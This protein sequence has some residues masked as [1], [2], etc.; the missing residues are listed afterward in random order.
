MISKPPSKISVKNLRIAIDPG[1]G[2]ASYG[3]VGPT[4]LA[5]KDIN[6]TLALKTADLLRKKGA[7]VF[8]TR[9]G[10][11]DVGLYERM[12]MAE[13]WGAD[14]FISIHNNAIPDGANPNE[15]SGMGIYYYNPSDAI[16][17]RCLQRNLLNKTGQVND[18]LIYGNLAVP[19]TSSMV[20]ILIECAYIINPEEEM[21]LQDV[22]FQKRFAKGVYLGVKDFL[23]SVE[24]DQGRFLDE[25]EKFLFFKVD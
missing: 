24:D 11:Y 6:L 15:Y 23:D 7:D 18:G 8:L 19:R 25:P 10:D 17:G 4:R 5:E 21:M 16:F 20:S 12:D 14:I 9:T 2:G 1:H 13:E 3:A 22:K